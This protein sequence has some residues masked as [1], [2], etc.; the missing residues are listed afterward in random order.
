[1]R[2]RDLCSLAVPG[3]A[4]A[5][6]RAGLRAGRDYRVVFASIDAREDAATL[7]TGMARV[8]AADRAGWRFVGGND[9]SARVLAEAVGFRYRY[10]RDRDAF[11]HPAGL[12]VLSPDGRVSRYFFGIRFE[13]ADLRLALAQAGQGRTGGLSDRLL[14]LCY[15]FDPA[16]GRYTP[17]IWEALR[18]AIAAFAAAAVLLAWRAVRKRK[19]GAGAP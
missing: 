14:L 4:E 5:L 2:C 10:E 11:A 15:H 13:P 19:A 3:T 16:T 9:A 8:P 6:D 7:A 18:L 17:R 1:V 12:V